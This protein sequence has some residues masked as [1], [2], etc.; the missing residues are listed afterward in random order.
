MG[1]S[2][3]GGDFDTGCASNTRPEDWG[4]EG[5]S[6]GIVLTGPSDTREWQKALT[7]VRRA[8]EL[9][10]HSVWVPESHF[11][12]GVCASPL[13]TLSGFAAQSRRLRLGTISLLLPIHPPLRLAAEIASLDSLSGGR[14]LIGLGRGFRAPLF[15]AFGI[16]PGSR[17]DRFDDALD[18]I[19]ASWRGEDGRDARTDGGRPRQPPHPPLAVAA[20]GRK[21]LAQAARRGLP[22]LASP[23][24]P[25][26]LLIENQRFHSENLPEDA[27]PGALAT[28]VLRTVHV[29]SSEPERRRVFEALE[30][31]LRA[32]GRMARGKA[33]AALARAVAGPLR[34]RVIVGSPSEVSDTLARYREE[35]G[36]DLLIARPQIAG[37][38]EAECEASL[39]R[40]AGEV[41]PGLG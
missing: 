37:A 19:L 39:E 4:I 31:E 38:S 20:F 12:R 25:L 1:H 30:A 33:P 22:Y 16:D 3:A 2:S 11:G 26:P 6:L 35:L 24:E 18:R 29:A 8:E 41:L 27:D 10:L 14:V 13:L 9:G 34:E 23:L 40:L 36:M 17:R 21:G 32:A 5:L 7:W 15:Q 28:P